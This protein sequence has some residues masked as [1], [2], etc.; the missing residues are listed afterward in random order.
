MNRRAMSRGSVSATVDFEV[1]LLM[2]MKLRIKNVPQGK[3]TRSQ[4]S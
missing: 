2:T 1:F 4:T 3:S